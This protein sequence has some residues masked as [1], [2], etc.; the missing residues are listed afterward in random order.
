[1]ARKTD[2]SKLKKDELASKLANKLGKD[3][4]V[5]ILEG[6]QDGSLSVE[7]FDKPSIPPQQGVRPASPE[8]IEEEPTPSLNQPEESQHGW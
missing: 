7:G 8:V 5:R 3:R 4:M 6:L 2:F 1:M